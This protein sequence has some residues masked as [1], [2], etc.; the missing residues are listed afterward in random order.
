MDL[1]SVIVPVYKVDQ[2]LNRCVESIVNQTYKNLEIILVDDGSPD[3]CPTICDTWAKKNS[4]I[5]VIHK[6][7]GGLSDARNAGLETATGQYIAFVDSDDWI[8]KTGINFIRQ[9]CF[10]ERRLKL[11]DCMRMSF[12]AIESLTNVEGW[13]L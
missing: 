3:D 13:H 4:R 1:I 2:Y 11:D 7:N 5:K 12:S 9:N 6:T 10:L 8:Q